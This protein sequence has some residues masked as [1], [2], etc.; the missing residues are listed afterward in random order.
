MITN[1]HRK[2]ISQVSIQRIK[3]PAA[4]ISVTRNASY[5]KYQPLVIT[6]TCKVSAIIGKSAVLFVVPVK[7]FDGPVVCFLASLREEAA[8]NFSVPAVVCHTF[9]AFTAP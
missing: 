6:A 3:I 2:L 9:T 4:H 5:S 1:T 8:G 7:V